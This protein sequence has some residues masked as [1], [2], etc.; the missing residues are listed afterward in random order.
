MRMFVNLTLL[1][2]LSA[3]SVVAQAD[4]SSC[5][6][7]SVFARKASGQGNAVW[8][9]T[10]TGA[11]TIAIVGAGQKV[12]RARVSEQANSRRDN[13]EIVAGH[14]TVAL[15]W[16]A[17]SYWAVLEVY[18]RNCQVMA[19]DSASGFYLSP[20]G[21]YVVRYRERQGF[22]LIGL[23]NYGVR[24]SSAVSRP[25]VEFDVRWERKRAVVSYHLAGKLYEIAFPHS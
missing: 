20:D 6:S 19:T 11:S 14:D 3:S 13:A 18:D 24:G 5:P 22:Q 21:E 15:V 4:V 10:T 8:C 25:V 1:T 23:D 12:C 9:G 16:G 17:G 7:T 2:A